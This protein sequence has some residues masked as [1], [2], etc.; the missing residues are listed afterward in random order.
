LSTSKTVINDK[1]TIYK[2]VLQQTKC[3]E[4]AEKDAVYIPGLI[5]GLPV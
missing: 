2:D 5:P 1:K 4:V 3:A